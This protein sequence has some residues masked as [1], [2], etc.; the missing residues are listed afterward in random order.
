[1]GLVAV[2]TYPHR[3]GSTENTPQ[4]QGRAQLMARQHG[5]HYAAAMAG[6]LLYARSASTGIALLEPAATPSGNHPTLWNPQGSRRIISILSLELSWVSGDCA[7]GAVEWAITENAGAQK[8]T[9]AAII[10]ATLV[11]PVSAVAG[12][13]LDRKG[14]W[15]PTVNTFTAAP[16][17]YRGAGISLFTGVAGTA[18]APFML[19]A[20]YDGGLNIAENTALSLC[21]QTTSTTAVFQ[22][23]ILYEE[24]DA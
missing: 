4:V 10:T 17:F 11:A 8:A 9:G 18:D 15:S 22:V 1:M 2:D 19:K 14:L 21:F 13:G 16:V 12:H 23:G 20:D 6:R 5:R 24:I 7:P 3:D